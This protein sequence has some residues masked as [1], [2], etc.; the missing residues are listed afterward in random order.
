MR[1]KPFQPAHPNAHVCMYVRHASAH[2]CVHVWA[3]V[4]LGLDC[5]GPPTYLPRLLSAPLR[6]ALRGAWTR[7]CGPAAQQQHALA[8]ALRIPIP[9]TEAGTHLGKSTDGKK[10]RGL[11]T[12]AIRCDAMRCVPGDVAPIRSIRGERGARYIRVCV[13]VVGG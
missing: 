10:E 9:R 6:G 4:G 11:E 7:C 5:T 12:D 13:V 8:L 3:Y 1:R 2:Q